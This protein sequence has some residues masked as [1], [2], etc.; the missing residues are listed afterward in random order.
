MALDK[1]QVT[2]MLSTMILI[3][4]FDELAI[5]L[6]VAGKIYGAVHPYV[7]RRRWRS[8][9]ARTLASATASP[10]RI[11]A[12]GIASPRARTSGA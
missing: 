3:R 1:S 10:A 7:G 12:T 4:E 2:Q 9:S 11:A 5:Q 6:R 8:G